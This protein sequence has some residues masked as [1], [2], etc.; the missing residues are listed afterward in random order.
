MKTS[1][2]KENI[3]INR[4]GE[5]PQSKEYGFEIKCLYCSEIVRV[6]FGN[7][8]STNDELITLSTD[9]DGI[10]ITI[11]CQHCGNETEIRLF[12]V[13]KDISGI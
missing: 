11:K 2:L 8:L 1:S 13:L 4:K 9:E 6:P 12:D 3:N 7:S 10:V 5:K